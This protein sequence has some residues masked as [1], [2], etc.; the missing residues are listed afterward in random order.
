MRLV[1]VLILAGILAGF[2]LS[3]IYLTS[4]GER[5]AEGIIIFTRVPSDHLESGEEE[6][7]QYYPGGQIVSIHP[8]KPLRSEKILTSDFYSACSPELSYDAKQMLF[9]AQRNKNDSWQVWEMDLKKG[10]SKKITDFEESCSGP[11]YLP[12]GRLAF[13][14]QL[15]HAV[16]ESGF[17]LYT[18]NLDGSDINRITFQ[19]HIDHSAAILQD[20]RILML[21]KQLYPEKGDWMYLAM[22]PNG[23]KAELF[24]KGAESSILGNQAY[25]TADGNIYFIHRE[26]GRNQESDLVSIHQNRPLFTKMNHTSEIIG[27]FY[28]AFPLPSGDLLVSYRSSEEQN[29]GLYHFSLSE[30]SLSSPIIEYSDYHVVEPVLVNAYSRPRNLPDEV[31]KMQ[32]TA[33]L[34]CQ[35]INSTAKQYGNAIMDP[36]PATRIEVLGMDKSL[37]VFPAEK[38]GSIYLK[39]MADT[40]FR[41][42]TLDDQGRVLN[43]PSAWLWLRPSERRGCVGC[44]ADPELV[45][46]NFVPLAVKKQPLSIPVSDTQESPLSPAVKIKK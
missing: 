34:L 12:G 3:G 4:C 36:S 5:S 31:D 44:H 10:T 42:Q 14:K 39:I 33:L 19:P 16:S 9:T 32:S 22:R 27:S 30:K 11:K 25:E 6:I 38:D 8:E 28:S 15:P 40:P 29:A 2:G 18:M 17:A 13:S 46:D 21:S 41:L 43:G 7:I 26:K 23:T 45:P 20:G 37:G 35:D 1:K 24:Y